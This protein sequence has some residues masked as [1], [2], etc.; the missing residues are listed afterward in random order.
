MVILWLFDAAVLVLGGFLSLFDDLPTLSLGS[1]LNL[2]VPVP[3][4]DG[5]AI[6]ALNQWFDVAL[7][8]FG[9]LVAGRVLQWI[10]SVIPFKAS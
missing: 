3:F 8:V 6:S 4:L 10:Y 2:T 7:V 9:A 1:S 5:A